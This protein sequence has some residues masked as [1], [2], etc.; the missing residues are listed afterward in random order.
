VAAT[1]RLAALRAEGEREA[2][3]RDEALAE[4]GQLQRQLTRLQLA[5]ATEGRASTAAGQQGACQE[6]DATAAQPISPGSSGSQPDCSASSPTSPALN[7]GAGAGSATGLALDWLN[8]DID[9]RDLT[10]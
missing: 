4:I 1:E 3:Y 9:D 10:S 6:A 7:L 2:L 8:A 5:P